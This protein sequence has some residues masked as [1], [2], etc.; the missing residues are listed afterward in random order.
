MDTKKPTTKKI[1][2]SD[3]KP[4]GKATEYSQPILIS[5]SVQDVVAAVL[6]SQVSLLKAV[7]NITKELDNAIGLLNIIQLK[8]IELDVTNLADV[9][10]IYKYE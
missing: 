1:K 10:D 8:L 6:N 5:E 4:L 9:V 7:T 2:G 3:F